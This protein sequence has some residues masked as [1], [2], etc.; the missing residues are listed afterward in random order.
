MDP[1]S[2]AINERLPPST[3]PAKSATYRLFLRLFLVLQPLAPLWTNVLLHK[4]H[5]HCTYIVTSDIYTNRQ[6]KGQTLIGLS[7]L[8]TSQ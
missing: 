7:T 4:V 1:L 8:Y 6:G 5:Q 3:L 2:C